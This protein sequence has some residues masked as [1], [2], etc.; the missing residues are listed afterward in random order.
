M[1]ANEH[2][3]HAEELLKRI[4]AMREL[5]ES[6]EDPEKVIDVIQ[7]IVELARGVESELQSARVA[8]EADASDA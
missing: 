1:S 8:A 7:E 3:E 6:L 4:E 5:L 2:L